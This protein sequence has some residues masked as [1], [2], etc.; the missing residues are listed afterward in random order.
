MDELASINVD[1]IDQTGCEKKLLLLKLDEDTYF[2]IAVREETNELVSL[3]LVPKD[4][5][6]FV[7]IDTNRATF[8]YRD[9]QSMHRLVIKSSSG[10]DNGAS[11]DLNTHYSNQLALELI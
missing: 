8:A 4:I 2:V 9:R 7:R 10:V 1:G 11:M 3:A 5:T 6:R